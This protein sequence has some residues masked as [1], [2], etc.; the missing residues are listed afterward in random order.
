AGA[1]TAGPHRDAPVPPALVVVA[2]AMRGRA[3]YR[4]APLSRRQIALRVNA[5]DAEADIREQRVEVADLADPTRLPSRGEGAR[6]NVVDR[7]LDPDPAPLIDE[8]LLDP[9]AKR[10]SRRAHQTKR[11]AHTEL[12]PDA[13]RAGTPAILLEHRARGCG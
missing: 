12:A 5:A 1:G 9:L 2:S 11:G 8:H 10:V 3:R 4:P 7:C 13:V 6:G